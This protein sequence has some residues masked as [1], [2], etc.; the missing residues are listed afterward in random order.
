MNDAE[1]ITLSPDEIL[2]AAAFIAGNM[3]LN[4]AVA[5]ARARK[6]EASLAALQ[7]VNHANGSRPVHMVD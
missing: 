2:S 1:P 7:E 4:A 6:A 5:E 3:F